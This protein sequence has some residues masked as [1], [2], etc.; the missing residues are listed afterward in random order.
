MLGAKSD[1]AICRVESSRSRGKCSGTGWT[2]DEDDTGVLERD[3]L[4]SAWRSPGGSNKKRG[5][6]R[7]WRGGFVRSS[8]GGIGEIHQATNGFL[9]PRVCLSVCLS[10]FLSLFSGTRT[11]T[12]DLRV[13]CQVHRQ[14]HD[15]RQRQQ[16]RQQQQQPSVTMLAGGATACSWKR[17][18]GCAVNG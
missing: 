4:Q 16:Q 5:R 15:G 14:T 7:K 10:F 2:F 17:E 18:S 9:Q 1:V 3:P 11:W 13:G 12:K 6:A 8:Y